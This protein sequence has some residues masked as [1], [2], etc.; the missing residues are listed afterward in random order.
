MPIVSVIIPA[1]N[2]DRYLSQA[3]ESVLNQTYPDFELIVIDDGSTD[4]TAI[5]AKNYDDQRVRYIYQ[6]NRG[7]S[8]ARNTGIRYSNGQHIT[9]LDSDDLFLPTKLQLLVTFFEE[10][11][12]IGLVAGQAVPI[13]QQGTRIGKIYDV[14]IPDDSSLLLL[15]NPLH[16]G[17]VMIRKTCQDL[18]GYFDENLHSY[19]DWDMWLRL[20]LA[21]CKAGWV[22]K[23]VSLYR[24]HTAQMTRIGPQMTKATFAVLDKIFKDPDL[25]QD[26]LL[27]RDKAYSRAYLRA[28]AQAYIGGDLQTAKSNLLEAVHLDGELTAD[29][30]A[31]LARHLSSLANSPKNP[32]P[33]NFLELIYNNLPAELSVLEQ[34]RKEDLGLMAIQQAFI[35]FRENDRIGSRRA[36][37]RAL[38]Y[39]PAYIK[40]RGAISILVRSLVPISSNYHEE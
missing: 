37:L 35:A 10:N 20:M 2:Q 40:N 9:F 25:P 26:W 30:A 3:I 24:F 27:L 15:G 1:Y 19:E 29:R 4:N 16:V 38:R 28:A 13:D 21:G 34:R 11:P 6:E 32:D 5:I 31:I 8:A 12:Q 39:H 18:V 36:I 23:P 22:A 17:S 7:L 33:M 14:P